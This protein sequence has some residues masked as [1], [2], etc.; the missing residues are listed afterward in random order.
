MYVDTKKPKTSSLVESIVG[1]CLA[2]LS[3]MCFVSTNQSSAWA[4][5]VP[6]HTRTVKHA[7]GEKAQ[8]CAGKREQL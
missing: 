8:Y 6:I 4:L 1:L 5:F 7:H 3:L 2:L